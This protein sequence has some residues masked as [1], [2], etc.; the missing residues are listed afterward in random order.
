M[1]VKIKKIKGKKDLPSL[2]AGKKSVNL[3][4]VNS[5]YLLPQPSP[6]QTQNQI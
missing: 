4:E 5:R 1:I 2:S 3:I 6:A